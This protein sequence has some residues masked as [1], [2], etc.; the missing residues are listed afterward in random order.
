MRARILML[1]VSLAV[2][3]AFAGTIGPIPVI[4]SGVFSIGGDTPDRYSFSVSGSDANGHAVSLFVESCSFGPGTAQEL[5]AGTDHLYA[6]GPMGTWILLGSARVDAVESLAFSFSLGGGGGTLTLFDGASNVIGSASLISYVAAGPVWFNPHPGNGDPDVV[7]TISVF[8]TPEP[9]GMW[10]T[11][12]GLVLLFV[13][14]RATKRMGLPP[15]DA[16]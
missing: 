4:G 11:T 7:G 6:P 2:F 12:I 9:G 14:R 1:A 13:V 15:W 5:T 16:T 10:M 8:Q 3:Q